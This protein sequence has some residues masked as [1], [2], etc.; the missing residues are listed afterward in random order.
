MSECIAPFF[1]LFGADHMCMSSYPIARLAGTP[2]VP[3]QLL[4]GPPELPRLGGPAE[5][6]RLTGPAELGRITG[7][8]EQSRIAG[9]PPAPAPAASCATTLFVPTYE[10]QQLPDE[11]RV[12]A[13]LE[14]SLPLDGGVKQARIPRRWQL[15]VWIDGHGFWR[16]DVTRGTPVG[17]LRRSAAQHMRQPTEA[18]ELLLDGSAV[19]DEETVESVRLFS[20][21]DVVSVRERG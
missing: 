13:G 11:A 20:R 12:P 6:S 1:L 3:A 18:V 8:P 4:T 17:E 2:D 5:Q 19:R 9:P 10:W 15:R 7:P 21:R 14:I 16:T